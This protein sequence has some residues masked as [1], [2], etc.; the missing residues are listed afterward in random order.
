MCVAFTLGTVVLYLVPLKFLLLAF[1]KIAEINVKILL[2]AYHFFSDDLSPLI[3][4][5]AFNVPGCSVTWVPEGF[6][7]ACVCELDRSGTHF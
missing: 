3:K 4:H 6:L 7:V 5:R 2:S 1:G